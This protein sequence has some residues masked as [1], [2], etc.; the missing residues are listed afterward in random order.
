MND[1]L[2]TGAAETVQEVLDR[3]P[4]AAQVFVDLR[5]ACIG[6]PM[7]RFCTLEEVAANYGLDRDS[8]SKA[9]RGQSPALN[10]PGATR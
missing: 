2:P 3:W 6:C 4:R 7:S 1:R 5:T 8:L 10:R 9:L